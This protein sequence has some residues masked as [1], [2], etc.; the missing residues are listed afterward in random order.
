[1]DDYLKTLISKIVIEE[2]KIFRN[3]QDINSDPIE[4]IIKVP[5]HMAMIITDCTRCFAKPGKLE[6]LFDVL[7]TKA[8]TDGIRSFAITL[9]KNSMDHAQ[10]M[11]NIN[12]KC[13]ECIS[14]NNIQTYRQSP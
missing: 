2:N 1:M 4:M 11:S 7:C 9:F 14:E 10:Y 3:N 5:K 8:F 13:K 12:P 6:E